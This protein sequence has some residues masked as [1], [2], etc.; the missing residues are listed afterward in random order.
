MLSREITRSLSRSLISRILRRCSFKRANL[1]QPYLNLKTLSWNT[2]NSSINRF[3]SSMREAE[4][5]T[6]KEEKKA[7]AKTEKSKL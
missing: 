3:Y 5:S 1:S 7:E 2:H 6:Q 4:N